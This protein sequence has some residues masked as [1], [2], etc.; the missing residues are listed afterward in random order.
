M[1][2]TTIRMAAISTTIETMAL[3]TSKLRHLRTMPR[4]RPSVGSGFVPVTAPAT[5]IANGSTRRGQR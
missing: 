3:M 4:R 1:R 2:M 5:V